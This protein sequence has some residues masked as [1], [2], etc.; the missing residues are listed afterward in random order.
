MNARPT[1]IV[2]HAGLVLL[3]GLLLLMPSAVAQESGSDSP[4]AYTDAL[5]DAQRAHLWRVGAWGGANALGGLALLLAS[6]RSEQPGR[7]GA[8]VQL[9][10]WG[11]INVG[12]ATLGLLSGGP[13]AAT[14]WA[15][16]LQSE[17]NYADILLLNLGLNVAYSAV[18]ATL[19]AVSYRGVNSNLSVRGHGAALI[20]QGLGLFILDGIAYLDTR[21]R[22]GALAEQVALHVGPMGAQL[23]MAF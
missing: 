2:P 20:L 1:P 21:G 19:V 6:K 10:A 22:W 14:T 9:T 8:G 15:E 3:V 13:D 18:G 17:N 12:I 23:T 7:F 11:T 16:A 4:V 5:H